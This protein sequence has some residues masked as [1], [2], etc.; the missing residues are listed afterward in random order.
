MACEEGPEDRRN[1]GGRFA[2]DLS[3]AEV[4]RFEALMTF[5]FT[6]EQG[7]M[8]VQHHEV[9]C[10]CA[11]VAFSSVEEDV[12][13]NSGDGR[14]KEGDSVVRLVVDGAEKE[15]RELEDGAGHR[16]RQRHPFKKG[17][18]VLLGICEAL[19]DPGD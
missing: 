12:G 13:R 5:F 15:L 4:S 6:E 1:P 2:R 18:S 3:I 8:G 17:S 14:A 10:V 9:A 7:D 19:A 16:C 11:R